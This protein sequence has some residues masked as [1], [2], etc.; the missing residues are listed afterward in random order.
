M[1]ILA[2]LALAFLFGVGVGATGVVL[3]VMRIADTQEPNYP[4]QR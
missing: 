3:M 1:S 2:A 4:E